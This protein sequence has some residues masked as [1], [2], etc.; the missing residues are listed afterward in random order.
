MSFNDEEKAIMTETNYVYYQKLYA[1]EQYSTAYELA[2]MLTET[3]GITTLTGKVPVK[4]VA[5][6]LN[7]K[8]NEAGL[9]KLYYRSSNG[10][11]KQVFQNGLEATNLPFVI[12]QHNLQLARYSTKTSI[13]I[14]NINYHILLP[15]KSPLIPLH[16]KK[17]A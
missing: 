1:T 6:Y 5:H 11:M 10:A 7:T 14:G 8:L 17:A 2:E 15:E 4:L 12:W 3:Y 13:K 16:L 9:P